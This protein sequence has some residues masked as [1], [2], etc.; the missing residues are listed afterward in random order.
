METKLNLSY[1]KPLAFIKVQT[2][3]LNPNTDRIVELSITRMES[4]G[5][6]KTG[7][8]LVNPGMPI[9]KEATEINGITDEAVK[10]KP[11]FKEIADNINKF[12]EGCDFV[13]FNIAYFD[14]KFLS[15]EFNRA[16]VEFTLLGRKVVDIANIYHAMEPRDLA[17]AYSFYCGKDMTKQNS[18]GT[19]QMYFE[20]INNMMSKYSGKEYTDKSGQTNKIE[21]TVESIN[22]LFNKNKKQL[23]IEGNIVLNDAG[24]PVFT[25][26]KYKDQ[27]VSEAL[28]KDNDYYEWIV[29]VSKF[30]ADTKLVIKK[31]V[32]K[33]KSAAI[34]K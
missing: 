25:M 28:L 34:A 30:P 29:D 1:V 21:P 31:I 16:G 19:T 22:N 11:S 12:L 15:E 20:I 13:G 17:A 6:V 24:R 2:T 32:E 10:S 23:D 18:E 8:R 27:V 33:A 14:L 7:T 26:G 3:G 9:P 4:D 5:K